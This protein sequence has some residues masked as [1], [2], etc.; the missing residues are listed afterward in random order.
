MSSA[1]EAILDAWKRP[2]D[3]F[4]A[5]QVKD[6]QTFME[7]VNDCDLVQD[8]TTDCSVVASLSA[9]LNILTGKRAVSCLGDAVAITSVAKRETPGS[10]INHVPL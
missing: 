7:P 10:L 1:Q 5:E 2:G 6:T 3:I 9:A 4:N 8:V